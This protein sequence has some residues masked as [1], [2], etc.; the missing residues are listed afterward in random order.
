MR[1]LLKRVVRGVFLAGVLED[2]VELR[3]ELVGRG[4]ADC[5]GHTQ[6]EIFLEVATG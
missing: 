4:A 5:G 3:N 1:V 6:R 2:A